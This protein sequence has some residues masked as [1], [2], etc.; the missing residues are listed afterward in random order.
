MA[1]SIDEDAGDRVDE[2]GLQDGSKDQTALL[3]GAHSM[4]AHSIQKRLQGVPRNKS[5]MRA[6]QKDAPRD[7]R[8]ALH[9][10]GRPFDWCLRP[11][12]RNGKVLLGGSIDMEGAKRSGEVEAAGTRALRRR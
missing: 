2:A 3:A 5:T 4:W 11:R 8:S 1:S 7:W 10:H 12:R 9:R 6:T